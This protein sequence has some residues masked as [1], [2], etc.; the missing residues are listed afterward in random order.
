MFVD[1]GIVGYA[2][3]VPKYPE[4]RFIGTVTI[5]DL[6]MALLRLKTTRGDLRFGYAMDVRY[7]IVPVGIDAGLSMWS[8]VSHESQRA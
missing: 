5:R 4:C 3:V 8:V 2:D 6:A 1:V 7:R